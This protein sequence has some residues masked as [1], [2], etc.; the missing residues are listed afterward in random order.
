MRI[1]RAVTALTAAGLL[2]ATGT[3]AASP[4]AATPA[5]GCTPSWKLISAPA[6]PTAQ[7]LIT[8]VAVDSAGNAW[9][10]AT[11][12]AGGTLSWADHWNGH[13]LSATTAIPE[14]SY[15]DRGTATGEPFDG[16]WVGPVS[17]DSP[18]DG[19]LIGRST[20]PD[21]S[22][23]PYFYATHW[24]GGR[25]TTTPLA[26]SPHPA[27]VILFTV[28]VAAVSPT[29]AWAVGVFSPANGPGG[30]LIEHWDGT[31]WRIFSNPASGQAGAVLYAITAVS[32]TDIWATGWQTG[33][34]GT[35]VPFAEH[36]DGTSWT[37]VPAPSGAAPSLFTAVSADS[38]SDAWAVGR[39]LEQGSSD[40]VTGLVEHWD[41]Q[42]WTVV[43][44]LPDLGNSELLGVY[45][46]SPA[47]V[48]ATV[49]APRPD[50]DLG[51]DEFLHWNGSSWTTVPVPGPH[52]YGLD[53]EYTG[54][55]GTGPGNIWAA[56]YSDRAVGALQ[57]PLIAHLSCG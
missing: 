5:G 27:S 48:W 21:L 8:G 9:F 49:Y 4:P 19:W 10:P 24:S 36:W 51:F 14:G 57:T 46:A 50:T 1:S 17:F 29:D 22:F 53:Y 39:Q 43:T 47:D 11:D 52:E 30:A 7:E 33:A 42:A 18:T 55:A 37:V 31:R 28:G 56:G 38:S 15:T 26:V 40:L 12:L 54:I 13:S 45:A 20:L 34:S 41:G 32:A 23:Y 6:G 16:P 25:W 2:A 44:G 35:N 3:G